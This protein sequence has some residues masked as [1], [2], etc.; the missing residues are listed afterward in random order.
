MFQLLVAGVEA[1]ERVDVRGDRRGPLVDV[2]VLRLAPLGHAGV[3]V[4]VDQ[5]GRDVVARDVDHGRFRGRLAVLDGDD[6]AVVDDD[7]GVDR[8][9][10]RCRVDGPADKRVHGTGFCGAVLNGQGCGRSDR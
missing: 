7:G 6:L 8:S 1:V 2:A 10:L 4:R 3:A 5:P 9:P